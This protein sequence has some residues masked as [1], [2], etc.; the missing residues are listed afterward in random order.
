MRGVA[1][2]AIDDIV[3]WTI[4]NRID[5]GTNGAA[6]QYRVLESSQLARIYC[7]IDRDDYCMLA[8]CNI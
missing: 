1:R 5:E 7:M 4:D 2:W 6:R 3:E 8:H